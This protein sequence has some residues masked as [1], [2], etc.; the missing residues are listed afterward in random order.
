MHTGEKPYDCEICNMASSTLIMHEKVHTVEKPYSCDVCQ[1]SYT[2]SASL[3]THN[4]TAAHIEIIKSKNTN[5]PLT[6]SSL[7]D[8]SESLK[9]EDI[10]E[11][12]NEEENVEHPY[13]NE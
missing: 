9:V 13:Y 10:L 2:Q 8:C 11:E 6:Q 4:K 1:K 3:F 5:L 7:V 12:I